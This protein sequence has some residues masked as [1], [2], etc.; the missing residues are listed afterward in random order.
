MR[1][2]AERPARR[3][4]AGRPTGPPSP[5]YRRAW[6]NTGWTMPLTCRNRGLRVRPSVPDAWRFRRTTFRSLK[7]RDEKPSTGSCSNRIAGTSLAPMTREC[8]TGSIFST[9]LVPVRRNA[10]GRRD[11]PEP[12]RCPSPSGPT[13]WVTAF[14]GLS[15]LRPLHPNHTKSSSRSRRGLHQLRRKPSRPPRTDHRISPSGRDKAGAL[16]AKSRR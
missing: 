9:D 7:N 12:Q 15:V 4:R 6:A 8:H 3:L 14:L 10:G 13:S 5:R 11:R 2:E 16:E 1:F